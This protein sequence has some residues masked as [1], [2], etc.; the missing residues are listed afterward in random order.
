MNDLNLQLYFEFIIMFR[1]KLLVRKRSC[2]I[3]IKKANYRGEKGI[4]SITITKQKI[5]YHE[6]ILSN[7]IYIFYADNHEI[8]KN[9]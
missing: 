9:Y 6:K 1:Y 4:Y 5:H 2:H 7:N 3:Y 8:F